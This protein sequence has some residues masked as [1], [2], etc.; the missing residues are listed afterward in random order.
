MKT[1]VKSLLV[2]FTLTAVTFSASWAT[3]NPGTRPSAV[4]A[5]K[6]GIY[7]TVSGKLHV[8]LDKETTGAVDIKLMNQDGTVLFAQ[9]LTKKEKVARLSFNLN[10]LPDGNYRLAITNGV[11]TTTQIITLA[12]PQP[13][14][15]S[16]LVAVN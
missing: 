12:T 11:D 14:L 16:R 5:Y 3:T 15:T 8:S 1:L 6:T 7:T 10:E 9:R 4:A 2:A 13:S